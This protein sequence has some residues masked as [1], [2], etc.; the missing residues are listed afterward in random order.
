MTYCHSC[1][2]SINCTC[3]LWMADVWLHTVLMNLHWVLKLFAG[4]H[5]V[6]SWPLVAMI[7]RLFFLN[8]NR[9]HFYLSHKFHHEILLVESFYGYPVVYSPQVFQTFCFFTTDT[10]CINIQC[11][12]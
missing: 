1:Y 11:T 5:L 4:H 10:K 7:K 9:E 8:R 6:S 2:F 3:T 12:V